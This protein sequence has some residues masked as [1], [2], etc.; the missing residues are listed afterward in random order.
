MV[1]GSEPS[2]C[3]ILNLIFFECLQWRTGYGPSRMFLVYR[4]ITSGG[5]SLG[6]GDVLWGPGRRCQRWHVGRVP[7]SFV[8]PLS[9]W[10]DKLTFYQPRQ[11]GPSEC[12][13]DTSIVRPECACRDSE[14]TTWQVVEACGD[15]IWGFAVFPLIS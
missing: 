2:F 5:F 7:V 10:P 11:A 8:C 15:I 6:G 3:E 1:L 12:S 4:R 14:C 9:S 13:Y